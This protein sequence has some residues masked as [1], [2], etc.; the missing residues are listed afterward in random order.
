MA[1]RRRAAPRAPRTSLRAPRMELSGILSKYGG[2]GPFSMKRN[3]LVRTAGGGPT[4][5]KTLKADNLRVRHSE[6]I[7]DIRSGAAA[8][9]IVQNL[10]INP[11]WQM[12][13]PWLAQLASNYTSYYV[14]G[15]VFE[16]RSLS[17]DVTTASNQGYIC[18][19]INPN[20]T[21]QVYNSKQQMEN[22]EQSISG[23]PSQSFILPVECVP[24]SGNPT[25]IIED[26]ALSASQPVNMYDLGSL[27]VAV[28]GNPTA[29]V[30]LGELYVTFDVELIGPNI[31]AMEG[32]MAE[33]SLYR[34]NIATGVDAT[35]PFSTSGNVAPQVVYDPIPIKFTAQSMYVQAG[36]GQ[37]WYEFSVMITGDAT[38]VILGSFAAVNCT[39]PAFYKGRT[40]SV[41]S[42]GGTT[43]T[44]LWWSAV[45]KVTDPSQDAGL[46]WTGFTMPTNV[47]SY[48]I[49]ATQLNPGLFA[50]SN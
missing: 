24:A 26:V 37:G 32:G 20:T 14:H 25:L 45:I 11:G 6:Y 7:V 35:H 22:S 15:M 34:G 28:G 50:V 29:D 39:K 1:K 17:G 33:T 44:I 31:Y 4:Y 43:S 30:I 42:N 2:Q 46:T 49:R 3:N 9:T 8:F 19:A 10:R 40:T 13:F 12:T 47:S 16:F 36:V 23:R 41:T 5:S 48:D 38:A 21:A 27:V 18:M